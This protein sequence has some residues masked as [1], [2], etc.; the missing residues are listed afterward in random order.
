M[1][2]PFINPEISPN[3]A[4]G[5]RAVEKYG[6]GG[7]AGDLNQQ[8]YNLK[9]SI[10][11]LPFTDQPMGTQFNPGVGVPDNASG[12]LSADETS[13]ADGGIIKGPGTGKSDSI[14]AKLPVDGAIIPE[15][16]V[17]LY[18]KD[19]FDKLEAAAPH[20]GKAKSKVDAKVSNGEY[21]LSPEAVKYW[22]ADFINKMIEHGDM[23]A[24]MQNKAAPDEAEGTEQPGMMDENESMDRHG[25]MNEQPKLGQQGYAK[26]GCVKGYADGGIVNPR[27]AAQEFWQ[28]APQNPV[29]TPGMANP[30]DPAEMMKAR[31]ATSGLAQQAQAQA[32]RQ[33]MPNLG[34]RLVQPPPL[35]P[36]LSVAPRALAATG[37][38]SAT[39][40]NAAHDLVTN[41]DYQHP[42]YKAKL[43]AMF[44]AVQGYAEGG[45]VNPAWGSTK[46]APDYSNQVKPVQAQPAPPPPTLGQ[47]LFGTG[48]GPSPLETLNNALTGKQQGYAEG[49]IV[50]GYA[51]GGIIP[52]PFPLRD[53]INNV[54]GVNKIG[55]ASYPNPALPIPSETAVMP[56]KELSVQSGGSLP[57][58][59]EPVAVTNDYFKQ[60]VTN[61]PNFTVGN[62]N[63]E[64]MP[65]NRVLQTT[66]AARSYAP[67][68]DFVGPDSPPK[69]RGQNAPSIEAQQYV[70]DANAQRDRYASAANNPPAEPV[71]TGSSF[72]KN[73]ASL[74]GKAAG[75]VSLPSAIDAMTGSRQEDLDLGNKLAG[76]YRD[77]GVKG[78][79]GY[80]YDKVANK[81]GEIANDISNGARR[82]VNTASNTASTI[83]NG[84]HPDAGSLGLA[85]HVADINAD[86]I[87]TQTDVS[88][89]LGS[90]PNPYLNQQPAG[91]TNTPE[92]TGTAQAS[93]PANKLGATQ[94]TPEQLTQMGVDPGQYAKTAAATAAGM[95][96]PL[97][98]GGLGTSLGL[99]AD[100]V[101]P[102][103]TTRTRA[104]N[105][106]D[107]ERNKL[108][109]A[110]T[111][112]WIAANAA[113][114]DAAQPPALQGGLSANQGN[115]F[116]SDRAKILEQNLEFNRRQGVIAAN[117]AA[118]GQPITAPV[119]HDT[120]TEDRGL[121]AKL[122]LDY[123]Q[124]AQNQNQ[125]D[126]TNKA[127]SATAAAEMALKRE[128]ANKNQYVTRKNYNPET[129]LPISETGAVFNPMTG[130][131]TQN[132]ASG[133][134]TNDN[135]YLDAM[136]QLHS[137]P[138]LSTQQKAAKIAELNA[139]HFGIQ[140]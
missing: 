98:N 100:G 126:Q 79:L 38:D 101:N 137:N 42:E 16:V 48:N 86:N 119:Y 66:S 35:A 69:V 26:G 62:N 25:M 78:V 122:G 110:N 108:D 30:A 112:Q 111:A 123:A 24:D 114:E 22:G 129:G 135:Y 93:S 52:D 107:V 74:A 116:L 97:G 104:R 55:G 18:G 11:K 90:N 83:W 120:G 61:E 75:A 19:Y 34:T 88:N 47:R 46:P 128:L 23:M 115:N 57:P 125:F 64:S 7:L 50:R 68:G 2:Q 80:E 94:Y 81:N 4:I 133:S 10:F 15:D 103:G 60:P 41:Y 49:G 77:N 113:R 106:Q 82:L 43:G 59:K 8:N 84:K 6:P 96:R 87:P 65:P 36:A 31:L 20:S 54:T 73:A 9:A 131:I 76:I 71:T 85:G 105:L 13:Y 45:V 28:N 70:T 21:M 136:K 67:N 1:P 14:P 40:G 37:V 29:P 134:G 109:N 118:N 72:L 121:A 39:V 102:D 12:D 51:E 140:Q 58:V 32:L 89:L 124:L 27:Q 99:E 117:Q 3:E 56:G 139:A 33:Q 95:Q 17:N 5:A 132:E 127:G 92:A 53:Q 63:P 138:K 130:Q 44:P 91:G